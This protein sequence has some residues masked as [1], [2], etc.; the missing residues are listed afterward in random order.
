MTVDDLAARYAQARTRYRDLK[1]D[2]RK[3][4]IVL[5]VPGTRRREHARV[6]PGVLG[7]VVGTDIHEGKPI[8]IVDVKVVDIER[9]LKRN[10][11]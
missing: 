7:R 3:A 1:L 6:L 9:W 4:H 8:T 11:A 2:E 10:A 5:V